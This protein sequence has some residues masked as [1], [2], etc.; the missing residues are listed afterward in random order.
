MSPPAS[1]W[2]LPPLSTCAVQFAAM[3]EFWPAP[4]VTITSEPWIWLLM[5]RVTT[6]GIL[7][8]SQLGLLGSGLR[9]SGHL[10]HLCALSATHDLTRRSGGLGHGICAWHA[11]RLTSGGLGH[12]S[13][14]AGQP[15]GALA[16]G[17]TALHAGFFGSNWNSSHGIS[18]SGT[19]A[20]LGGSGTS[21]LSGSNAGPAVASL[22]S[23]V[24]RYLP[25]SPRPT[26]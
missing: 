15:G 14:Q 2:S 20:S 6:G 13:L 5:M 17:Q 10:G 18:G 16:C 23:T 11:G 4:I 8:S 21:S 7:M 19:A 26:A 12:L 1:G 25:A 3:P 24:S 9:G 22:K